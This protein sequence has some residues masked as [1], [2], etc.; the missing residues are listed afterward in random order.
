[1]YFK[2]PLPPLYCRKI[3][4]VHHGT[5]KE[6]QLL[7]SFFPFLKGG[8]KGDL[9]QLSI[10]NFSIKNIC[11]T[12]SGYLYLFSIFNFRFF[13]IPLLPQWGRLGWGCFLL[14]VISCYFTLSILIISFLALSLFLFAVCLLVFVD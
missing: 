14:Q 12:V 10:V 2:S 11:H 7:I 13:K 6:G 3:H 1:M 9:L 8:I 5:L 4:F